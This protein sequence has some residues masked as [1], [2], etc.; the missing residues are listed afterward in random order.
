MAVHEDGVAGMSLL[1]MCTDSRIRPF[2]G[3]AG[4]AKAIAYAKPEVPTNASLVAEMPSLKYLTGGDVEWSDE[5][6]SFER[7]YFLPGW[8]SATPGRTAPKNQ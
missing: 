8:R 3:S 1:R 2:A 7:C 5:A 4:P 6:I